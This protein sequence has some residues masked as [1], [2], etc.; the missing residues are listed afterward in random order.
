MANV[1]E[2][3]TEKVT[4]KMRDAL[5][6]TMMQDYFFELADFIQ[7]NLQEGERFKCWFSGEQSDF[8]RFNK[9]LVRQPGN[10]EQTALSLNLIKGLTHASCGFSL[11][12]NSAVDQASALQMLQ[13]L[14]GQIA[15]LPEDPH[16]MMSEEPYSTA[17]IAASGE[18]PL[19]S[20]MVD[21][22]LALAKGVDFVG[23]LSSGPI[24]RGFAN[25]YGQRNW[26]QLE[27]FI[28]DWSIYQTADKAVK[29]AYSGTQWDKA[30]LAAKFSDALNQVEILKREAISVP[31]GQYRAYLTPT[32]LY[33]VLGM[34]NWDGV[35]EKSLRTKQSSIRRMRDEDVQF[36]K[37]V[38]LI[39]NTAQGL[40]PAFQG[41]G[42]VKPPQVSIIKAG[43]LVGS[44]IS[45]RTAQEYGLQTN[46]ADGGESM[47]A[48][49]METGNLPLADVLK[50]LGTGIYISN[51]WYLNFSDR[52]ACKITGMTRFASFWV[53]NGEI[54]APLNVM[55]FDDSLF[56]ILGDKL[57]ALTDE[58]E[59]L[60]DNDTYEQRGDSC[61]RL[62]GALIKDFAFVL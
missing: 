56:S 58:A 60:I 46:A 42:F 13:D 1:T 11:S 35:G 27:S 14:R 48:M 7:A 18:L 37:M 5:I 50:E 22:I 3:V 62:P 44:M 2:N 61:A 39:E 41:D 43:R 9:G 53:E 30:A 24:F 52:S 57:L 51:M 25:S 29:C 28:L 38:H 19:A 6:D 15:Q 55:R 32:A 45:P 26:H 33:E 8:V 16:F 21:D 36:N 34:L 40:A 49:E 54:K 20:Q 12:K 4:E 31:P 17:H 59:M 23:V 47:S 10:V